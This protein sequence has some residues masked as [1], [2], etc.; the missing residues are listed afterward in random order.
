MQPSCVC[1]TVALDVGPL[2]AHPSIRSAQTSKLPWL[3]LVDGAGIWLSFLCLVHCAATPVLV[4][5]LPLLAGHEFDLGV[6]S[7]LAALGVCGV[8]IGALVHRNWG[9]LLPLALAL[10][11]FGALAAIELVTGQHPPRALDFGLGGFASFALMTAHALN[12][13]ACSE[14]DHD[15]APGRWFADGV[16]PTRRSGLDRSFLVALAFAGALHA[17]L[18]GLAGQL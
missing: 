5:A 6:R 8:G 3:R 17:T 18:I 12:T 7:L 14:S 2:H 10:S 15:C 11:T 13:R 1:I 4:L 9:A 16:W